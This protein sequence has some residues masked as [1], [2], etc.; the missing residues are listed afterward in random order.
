MRGGAKF[1]ERRETIDANEDL[2]T[3][4][5]E[6]M[7]L[8]QCLIVSRLGS[9]I[10]SR[11]RAHAHSASGGCVRGTSLIRICDVPGKWREI[12]VR[13]VVVRKLRLGGTPRP[14]ARLPLLAGPL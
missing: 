14:T 6:V 12:T 13:N 5:Y 2:K 9:S 7:R 3:L 8:R 10:V 4:D 11:P 1:D